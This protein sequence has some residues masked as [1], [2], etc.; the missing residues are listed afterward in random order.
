MKL[1]L[2][3]LVLLNFAITVGILAQQTEADRKLLADIRTKAETGNA[4]SQSELGAVFFFGNL[5]V[6]KN[7]EEVVKWYRKA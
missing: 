2:A 1:S 6:P 4:Q 3:G 7:E 5:G